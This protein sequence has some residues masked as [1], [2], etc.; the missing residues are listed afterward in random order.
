MAGLEYAL[1]G[2]LE[3]IVLMELSPNS[4]D[5]TRK[6]K[7]SSGQKPDDDAFKDGQAFTLIELLVVIAIIAVLAALLLPALARSKDKA[8]QTQCASNQRQIALGW[9]MYV[10]DYSGHYP[11]IRGWGGAGGQAGSNNASISAYVL[12][13]FGAMNG[14]TNRPLNV[15]VTAVGAWQCPSD[16]GDVNYGAQNCFQQYGNSYCTQLDVDAWRVLHVVADSD[17]SFASGAVPTMENVVGRSPVN[18]IIQGDWEWEN[19][20]YSLGNPASWW[21]NYGG[22]RRFNMLFGDGHVIFF[23]FPSDTPTF[24]FSPAPDPGYIYW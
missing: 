8:K 1:T 6:P 19:Q 24:Q 2:G 18:K 13:S 5:M 10:D 12:D 22:Q 4:S 17:P 20:S 15:Y 7:R 21:H 11:W 3:R 16:K 9:K 14:Y 23:Q